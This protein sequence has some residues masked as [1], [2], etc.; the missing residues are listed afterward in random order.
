[1]LLDLGE[2]VPATVI[3]RPSKVNRSPYVADCA[4]EGGRSAIVHCPSMDFGGKMPPGTSVMVKQS[5]SYTADS[6]GKYGKPKCEFGVK[7]LK[8]EE[9]EN[10]DIGGVWIGAQ[11]MMGEDLAK[12]M[13]EKNLMAPDLP[14]IESFSQQVTFPG[15][16]SR[17]DF[18]LTHKDGSKTVVEIKTSVDTCYNPDATPPDRDY[19]VFFSDKKP[20]ER[21]SIFP[22]GG[23]CTQKGPD[24]EPV[25]SE[26]LIKHVDELSRIAQGKVKFEKKTMNAAV[27]FICI[28]EDCNEFR[29]NSQLDPSFCKHL[30]AAHDHGV[31]ILARRVRFG[32]G[33]DL[34]KAFYD[35]ALPVNLTPFAVPD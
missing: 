17:L 27:L 26:R 16:N 4:V 10:K 23:K 7:L 3:C 11:P 25:V 12:V 21:A 31:K 5:K 2:L 30:V 32:K 14:D 13:F 33:D 6:K 22:A 9:S 24:G 1:V 19:C 29:P 35:G 8:C 15:T 28:R 20:Y 34:G 18:V